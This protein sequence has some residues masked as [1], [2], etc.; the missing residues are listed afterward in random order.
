MLHANTNYIIVQ[1]TAHMTACPPY[2]SQRDS[3]DC[4][5]GIGVQTH[6]ASNSKGPVSHKKYEN[7][8]VVAAAHPR[9]NTQGSKAALS[10]SAMCRNHTFLCHQPI[11][12]GATTA[13][14]QS[15]HLLCT[16]AAACGNRWGWARG[17]GWR[18]RG[19]PRGWG[20]AWEP[21]SRAGWR[22]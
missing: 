16:R 5:Y 3:I 11:S 7:F 8:R 20:R 21:R 6:N 17:W 10:Q 18:S 19:W 14:P 2:K 9:H 12:V 1:V 13:A 4:L 22:R 15:H